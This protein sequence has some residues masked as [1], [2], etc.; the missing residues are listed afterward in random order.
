MSY[1]EEHRKYVYDLATAGLATLAALSL[2][3]YN[4]PSAVLAG[5]GAATLVML[6]GGLIAD[7]V[8]HGH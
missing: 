1:D 2:A 6:R 4:A 5:A 7:H 3:S 8:E